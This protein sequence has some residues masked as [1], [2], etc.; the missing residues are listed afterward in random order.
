M[1]GLV[2]LQEET[3]NSLSLQCEDTR[4]SDCNKGQPGAMD[5]EDVILSV[6]QW[7]LYTHP[8]GVGLSDLANKNSGHLVN[9]LG[10][11]Y[12]HTHTE[13]V[14]YLTHN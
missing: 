8:P 12:T 3:Q 5:A 9:I 1:V 14:V 10:H 2:L 6:Q 4:S 13:S 7:C 11:T